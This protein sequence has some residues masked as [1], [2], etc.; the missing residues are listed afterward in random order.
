MVDR[1]AQIGFNVSEKFDLIQADSVVQGALTKAVAVAQQIT[2]KQKSLGWEVN[3]WRMMTGNIG[4][5][6]TDD[7]TRACS[8]S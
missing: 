7:L 1:L 2:D 6:G 5:Y 3:G 8:S 4:N